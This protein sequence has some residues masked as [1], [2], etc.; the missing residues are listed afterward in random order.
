M[1]NFKTLINPGRHCEFLASLV[2]L[3]VLHYIFKTFVFFVFVSY[4]PHVFGYNI[5][6]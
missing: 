1:R 2:S 4:A 3:D 6:V 5:R